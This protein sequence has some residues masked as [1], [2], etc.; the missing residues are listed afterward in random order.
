M[1]MRSQASRDLARLTEHL[2]RLT[3][4]RGDARR[5]QSAVRR[6]ELFPLASL[7]LRSRQITS[8]PTQA[9]YN[10]LQADVSAIF[11]ALRRI[12]NALGNTDLPPP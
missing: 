12:S 4:E 9:D 7:Q 5:S 1:T 3:G 11:N 10:A 6:S 2:E 8:A